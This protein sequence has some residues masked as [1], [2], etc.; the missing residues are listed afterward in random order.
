MEL[1]EPKLAYTVIHCEEGVVV[2][3]FEAPLG[4]FVN[5]LQCWHHQHP[6]ST[7]IQVNESI[8]AIK[9]GEDD[10]S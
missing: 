2:K 9:F 4:D 1:G 6:T 10:G 5:L 7:L 8:L 3:G